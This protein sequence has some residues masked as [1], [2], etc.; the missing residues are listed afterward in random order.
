MALCLPG[1]LQAG[2]W[3]VGNTATND[4]ITYKKAYFSAGTYR[5]TARVGAAT[6]G[7]TIHL[8]VDGTTVTSGVAVPNTGRVDKFGY[9]H[10]GV[11]TLTAGVHD[12]QIVFE[13]GGA[14]LDWF[15]AVKDTDTSTSVKASDTTM[16][17]PPTTGINF[18]PNWA[19][20][21]SVSNG[22]SSSLIDLGYP[23]K[24]ANGN[25]YT[26]TQIQS[27]FAV[28]MWRDYDRRTDRYWDQMVDTFVA[29]RTQSLNTWVN[30]STDATDD[31]QDRDMATF[32]YQ[33]R[34]M[35]KFAEAVARNPQAAD[36]VKTSIRL[37]AGDLGYQFQKVNGYYPRFGDAAL[38]HFTLDNY[39]GPFLDNVP[40]SMIF[41][42]TPGQ[43]VIQLE[44]IYP[45]GVIRDGKTATY[46]SNLSA[47][48]QE[49]YG[50]TP[51]FVCFAGSV[52]D[53]TALAQI[54]GMAVGMG[55]GGPLLN[56]YSYNG[57]YFHD[58]SPGSRHG[59]D[60]VWLNDWN[61]A[62]DT[63]TPG[64]NSAGVEAHQSRLDSSGNSTW[65][66]NLA[67][68]ASLGG[69]Y[70]EYEGV[71]DIIEGDSCL[72]SYYPEFVWP[73]QHIAAF[74]QFADPVTQTALFEAE[75]CDSYVKATPVGNAG[76]TY[77]REWYGPTNLDVYRP[78]HNVLPWT[79]ASSGPGN[80]TSI[81]AGFFDT[82]TL[83]SAGA[84][85]GHRISGNPDIWTKV[86]NPAPSA[87]KVVSLGRNYAWGLT[88]AGAVY[89]AAIP[90]PGACYINT[91]WSLKSG[92]MAWLD[93][94]DAEVWATDASGNVYRQ[95]IDGTDAGWTSVPGQLLDKVW[96]GDA[97][98]WGIRGT[99]LYHAFIPTQPSST[100]IT[101]VAVANPN[102][103]T[104]LAVG[105]DEVWGINAAGNIYRMSA[106]A[107]VGIWDAVPGPGV[108]VTSIGVGE[109]YAWVLSGSNPY[110]CKLE[111]FLVNDPPTAPLGLRASTSSGQ[112]VLRWLPVSG[113]TTYTISRSTS[114][115][116]TY[117]TVGTSSSPTFK[118][119]SLTNGTTYYYKITATTSL[120]TSTASTALAASPV[121]A[122]ITPTG[123]TATAASIG[124]INL[125][126]T[127]A[128]GANT[129]GYIIERSFGYNPRSFK[130][131]ARIMSG[132]T[133]TYSDTPLASGSNYSYR[134]RAYN[135]NLVESANSSF[136]NATT[137]GGSTIYINFQPHDNAAPTPTVPGYLV[138]Y[139]QVY[140]S[141]QDAGNDLYGGPQQIGTTA[142]KYGWSVD[143]TGQTRIRG[144]NANVLLDTILLWKAGATWTIDVPNGTYSVLVAIG[145]NQDTVSSTVNVNGVNFW[146][147]Q[148]MPP[149]SFL[150]VTKAVTVTNGKIV[151]DQG[152]G[153]N[154]AVRLD[155]V[156]ITPTGTPGAAPTGLT[157]V[158]GNAQVALTWNAV[159][160]ASSYQV[161][162]A[163]SPNGP[164]AVVSSP[165]T[166]SYTDTGLSNKNITYYYR[167]SAVVSGTPTA[168]SNA[169]G[170]MPGTYQSPWLAQS[171]GGSPGDGGNEN[172][173]SGE[174]LFT[175]FARGSD[176]Q[177]T[178]DQFRFVYQTA[179]GDCSIVA[180][181]Y[182][183]QNV[184][185]WSKFGIMIR[186][187][188]A[189]DST[190]ATVLLS[191]N[192]GVRFQYRSTTS[193][194]TASAG[195]A[196]I[197]APY[198]LK[199]TRVGNVFTGYMSPD[200]TTWTQVGTPQTITMSSTTYIGLAGTSHDANMW[201]TGTFD[202]VLPIP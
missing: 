71:C 77:R 179:T 84:M 105:A 137:L 184:D 64:G 187:T 98:V 140:G 116:G 46:L 149:N 62:T 40:A 2:A 123:L 106:S 136:V 133:T 159:S 115:G 128:G 107:A 83:D 130:T 42:P 135:S 163:M 109:T 37:G 132:G 88:T 126:W 69:T 56:S 45:G 13:N 178:S 111:G 148:S 121:A 122:P 99:T 91:G 176:I 139:G 168:P 197:A 43:F 73:N 39:I 156:Q 189:A 162:R 190:N 81:T 188:L 160:G 164:F 35:Q 41:Q 29:M 95:S 92:T 120:G 68:A 194:T 175:L 198:W 47:R 165:A 3:Y 150:N 16:V 181:V 134:I 7:K 76:G 38:V 48:I 119:A 36:T 58:T 145:D 117:T 72:R 127:N 146:T 80:L 87:F 155:Y 142:A 12:L 1:S 10:L 32:G 124:Q 143:S 193:G 118:D 167:V 144:V 129:A 60:Q 151:M 153:G 97:H 53:P 18:Y 90:T 4:S 112:T 172:Y 85:W 196:G 9:A 174:L 173:N 49:K 50:L 8:A 52:L 93:A 191:A 31:L 34:F 44:V 79:A 157:G 131:V 78:L 57:S 70:C 96:V 138:D 21:S 158:S 141:Q 25:P 177:N 65:L 101:F 152:A 20:H 192:N 171:I 5:F 125:A 54:W 61:P 113:A 169:I 63:G 89:R 182:G 27:Y 104:Q 19:Y 94:G 26:D 82:W 103:L 154:N 15:M 200:G 86:F 102:N 33:P 195:P 14:S 147:S 55:W 28:P 180:R 201:G 23:V 100:A 59:L 199:L 17:A 108:A 114:L 22:H 161:S 170:T 166:T 183:I 185:P 6:T 202:C 30:M 186:E 110:F 75:A 67:T 24:D 51:K 74:R 66:T 11:K